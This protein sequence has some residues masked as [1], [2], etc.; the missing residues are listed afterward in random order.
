M[1]KKIVIVLMLVGLLAAFS[2]SATA[3][4]PVTITYWDYWVT[5]APALEEGIALFEEMNPNI[6]VQRTLQGGGG[7]EQIIQ[8]AFT[9]GPGSTPDVFVLPENPTFPD[10]VRANWLLPLNDLEGFDEWYVQVPNTEFV[11]LNG[12]GNTIDGRT[13]STKF[14]G[15]SVWIKMFV[16]TQIYEDAGLTEA[17]FP[18]TLDQLNENSRTIVENTDAYGLG[19]SG[20]QAWAQ[21]WWMWMCQFSTQLWTYAPYPGFNWL[22]GRF[23]IGSDECANAALEGLVQMRDEGLIHPE[24]LALAIDDEGARVLFATHQFAHLIAGDWVIGGWANTNPEFSEFRIIPLPLAGVEEPGG[25]FNSGPGGRWFGIAADTEHPQE[26]FEFFKFLHSPEFASI[27]IKYN[28]ESVYRQDPAEY[29]TT[30]IRGDIADLN[31]RILP[32]PNLGLVNPAT[33]QVVFTLQGPSLDDLVT[34]VFSYQLNDI[35][36]ALA[37]LEARYQAAFDQGIADAQAAGIDVSVED[38]I[39]SDWDPTQPYTIVLPE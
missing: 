22:E 29:A 33:A 21:G 17:D 36:A 4:E 24:T 28:D 19:F 6:R 7:Y 26:A 25:S 11:H 3:Q 12:A 32:G 5:Q 15:D 39:L 31:Q 16:N 34:G 37:D 13:Y 38:Y 18:T 27:W 9:A 8:A 30:P 10:Q 20:T 1:S 35:G 14:W 23:D 2:I